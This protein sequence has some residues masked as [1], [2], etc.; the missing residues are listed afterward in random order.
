MA[1]G[2]RDEIVT[3]SSHGEDKKKKPHKLRI[4]IRNVYIL[5]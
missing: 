1:G 2:S 5:V 3:L 4:N